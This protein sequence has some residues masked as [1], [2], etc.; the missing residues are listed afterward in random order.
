MYL[1]TEPGYLDTEPGALANRPERRL[2]R[3][4][5]TILGRTEEDSHRPRFSSLSRNKAPLPVPG[6]Q[7][8]APPPTAR[9][10]CAEGW[11]SR[12]PRRQASQID[13][14]LRARMPATRHEELDA[15][16]AAIIEEIG[17]DVTWDGGTYRAVVADPR[18][19]LD[20]QT[21]GF[22]PEA[23]FQVKLRKAELPEPGPRARQTVSIRGDSYAIKGLTD[24]PTSPLLILHVA[25][26]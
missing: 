6:S 25:R 7:M 4:V 19:E 16:L 11:F 15:D 26:A 8:V 5:S 3:H 14:P 20:L 13:T 10:L 9:P 2:R 1:D 24:R 23:D 18:V 17:I 12:R 22:M 21:G